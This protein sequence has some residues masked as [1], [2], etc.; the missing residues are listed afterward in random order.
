M[1]V[2][3]GFMPFVKKYF[4][5]ILAIAALIALV[6]ALSG[7]TTYI[8]SQQL[9]SVSEIN[10][11]LCGKN[12]ANCISALSDC[13]RNITSCVSEKNAIEQLYNKCRYDFEQLSVF[14]TELQSSVE[15]Y[16]RSNAELESKITDY[17]TRIDAYNNLVNE[18]QSNL[19]SAQTSIE[20]LNSTIS[21]LERR[22]EELQKE[23]EAIVDNAAKSICCIQRVYNPELKYYYLLNNSIVC[24]EEPDETLGTKEFTCF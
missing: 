3:D 5:I 7:Y 16:K 9:S 18:L 15:A 8:L 10:K 20:E 22:L 1:W 11:T 14:V 23:R 6:S 24:T 17:K 19:T 13:K 4:S 12:L 21:D 2:P